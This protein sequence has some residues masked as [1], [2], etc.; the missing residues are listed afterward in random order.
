MTDLYRRASF[1]SSCT[2]RFFHI[3]VNLSSCFA[4]L[5]K[6]ALPNFFMPSM[7]FF[8]ITVRACFP[9]KPAKLVVHTIVLEEL[10]TVQL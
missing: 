7:D 8:F 2:C 3:S 10:Q 4:Y 6:G 1:K 9:A 5:D